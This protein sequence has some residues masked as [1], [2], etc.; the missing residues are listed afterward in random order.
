MGGHGYSQ[1]CGLS[2]QSRDFAVMCSWEGDN[3]VMALQTG[4]S[5][6]GRHRAAAAAAARTRGQRSLHPV[7]EQLLAA[8]RQ[9]GVVSGINSGPGD[10]GGTDAVDSAAASAV[11]AVARAVSTELPRSR[12]AAVA[13]ACSEAIAGSTAQQRAKEDAKGTA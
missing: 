6:V 4:R 12:A 1:Y 2:W 7:L 9:H 11:A 13:A 3:V 5:I 8:M 10:E